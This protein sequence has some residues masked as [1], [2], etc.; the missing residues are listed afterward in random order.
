MVDEMP[1]RQ[2]STLAETPAMTAE[3]ALTPGQAYAL[4]RCDAHIRAALVARS[5][6]HYDTAERHLAVAADLDAAATVARWDLANDS[7]RERMTIWA[8]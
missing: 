1:T 7:Q 3:N 5:L 6:G 8:A 4:E 2:I